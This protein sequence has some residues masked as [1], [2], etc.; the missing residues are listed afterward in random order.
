VFNIGIF[1][2]GLISS[3]AHLY[4]SFLGGAY[5]RNIQHGRGV[6]N[7]HKDNSKWSGA[8]IREMNARNGVGSSKQRAKAQ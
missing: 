4:E 1:K 7:W 6:R 5:H 8:D 2:P 3:A